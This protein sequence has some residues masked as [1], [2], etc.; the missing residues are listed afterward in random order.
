MKRTLRGLLASAMLFCGYCFGQ[1]TFYVAP[2]GLDSRTDA[3]GQNSSTPFKTPNRVQT[4]I[5]DITVTAGSCA[6]RGAVTVYFKTSAYYLGNSATNP[7]GTWT[8]AS[9]DTCSASPITYSNWVV[10]GVA[11]DAGIPILSG[12]IQLGKGMATWTTHTTSSGATLWSTSG[13]PL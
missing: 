2:G 7:T 4:A 9:G 12:G 8:I 6:A 10:G 3:Q 13:I 11:Q 1:T 5:H